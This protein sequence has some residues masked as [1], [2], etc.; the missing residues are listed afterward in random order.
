MAGPSEFFPF[1]EDLLVRVLTAALLLTGAVK[2][3]T[4]E[5]K[6][7]FRLF[8]GNRKPGKRRRRLKG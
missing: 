7:V 4:P 2:I 1:L 5:V 6:C 3:I 8:R